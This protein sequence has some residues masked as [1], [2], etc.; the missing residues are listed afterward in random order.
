MAFAALAILSCNSPSPGA[1]EQA[2]QTALKAATVDASA[3]INLALI[4][5]AMP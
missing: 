1:A 4:N 5:I 3:Q 2:L